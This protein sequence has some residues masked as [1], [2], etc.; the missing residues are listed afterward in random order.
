MDKIGIII[1]VYNRKNITLD[2]IAN[3]YKIPQNIF[4]LDIYIV[5]DGS[6][7]GTSKSVS[8]KFPLVKI[9][10]TKG[11]FWWA[12]SI[13][14]GIKNALEND[15]NYILTLNDDV[16]FDSNFIHYLYSA[17]KKYP[18]SIIG[19]STKYY[20]SSEKINSIYQTGYRY[21]QKKFRLVP[22]VLSR[23]NFT[24]EKELILSDAL[25][26]RSM[27][28]P[29]QVF[30]EIGFFNFR[31][32]PQCNMDFDFSFMA[33]KAGYK[34][35]ISTK[36]V[37]ETKINQN[38]L[39]IFYTSST[40]IEFVKSLFSKKFSYSFINIIGSSFTKEK[41]IFGLLLLIK[42]FIF[43]FGISII[44]IFSSKKFSKIIV[45]YIFQKDNFYEHI[46]SKQYNADSK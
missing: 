46:T 15:C 24:K 17:I 12:K 5:D 7:D 11:N 2:C 25:A 3:L 40:K 41:N 9:I 13:N 37:V 39:Y 42:N 45:N 16:N 23:E 34:L 43:I 10:K 21:N 14:I 22:N 4:L 32:R 33:K 30:T 35:L 1:P 36:S 38:N 6:T 20:L 19:S 8:N 26:G 44:K 29:S 18:K 27:F 31:L 28:I